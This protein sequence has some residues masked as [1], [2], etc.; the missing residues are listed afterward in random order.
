MSYRLEDIISTLGGQLIGD[1]KTVIGKVGT[2]LKAQPGAIAFLSNP[3]YRSQLATTNASAVII[4]PADVPQLTTAG[5]VTDNPYLY[6]AKLLQLLYPADESAGTICP[7]AV[8]DS[9]ASVAK[10]AEIGAGVVIGPNVSVGEYTKVGPK[11]VIGATSQIGDHC[12]IHANVTIYPNVSIGDR[13]IVHSGAVIGADGFGF[14]PDRGKWVK[15]PQIG[16]VVI[17]HDVEIG[18]NSTIDSGAIEPTIIHDGVKIDNLV[19]VAHNVEIGQHTVIAACT[20][21]SGSTTIGKHCM[22]GGSVGTAGHLEI[23]DHT[24]LLGGANVTKSIK[25]PGVYSSCIPVMPQKQW[26][27]NI[28]HLKQL[29]SMASSLKKLSSHLSQETDND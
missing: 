9:T 24:V 1:G 3:K 6:F 11:T 23:A 17:G 2:L 26:L 13:V 10:T 21:I 25:T 20:G 27:R 29:D 15:I 8:I 18:A 22:L 4:S 14:A 12:F 7:T 16:G 5:I 28:A 19:M